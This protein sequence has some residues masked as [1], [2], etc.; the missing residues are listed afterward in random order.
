MTEKELMKAQITYLQV[1]K[2][3][4]NV[5]VGTPGSQSSPLPLRED[6]PK[7]PPKKKDPSQ[8]DSFEFQEWLG[9]A[10]VAELESLGS[11]VPSTPVVSAK[12]KGLL[13]WLKGLVCGFKG[14]VR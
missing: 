4:V 11:L 10:S 3:R 9:T 7:A 2:R 14:K 13:G 5:P 8:M 12:G 6:P 1:G